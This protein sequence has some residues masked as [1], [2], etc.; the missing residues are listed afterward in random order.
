ME[1]RFWLPGQLDAQLL[2]YRNRDQYAVIY[3][4]VP[5]KLLIAYSSVLGGEIKIRSLAPL[6]VVGP[7]AFDL[8]I[9]L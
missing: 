8:K 3:S 2:H 5:N 4:M 9:I 6:Q 1:D 7:Q